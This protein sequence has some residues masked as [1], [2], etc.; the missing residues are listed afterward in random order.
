MHVSDQGHR[1]KFFQVVRRSKPGLQISS[2]NDQKKKTKKK[3]S[4]LKFSPIICPKSG[5]DQKKKGLH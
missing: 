2:K 5:E 1:E 4:S 3:R